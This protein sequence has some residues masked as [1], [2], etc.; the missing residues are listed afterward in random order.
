VRLALISNL[1]PGPGRGGAERYAATLAGA[2]AGCGHEVTLYTG[3]EGSIPGVDC[4]RLPG[5]PELDPGAP[6]GSK[7]RWH[8]REQWLPGVHRALR[9]ALRAS[10][11]DVVHTHETQLLSAAVFTAIA[12]AKVPHV[13]TA[14]DYNLLC[15]RV[16]M[17][18]D[19]QPCGGECGDCRIQRAIRGRAIQRRLD[20]LLAPSDFVRER[21]VAYGIV[22]PDRA[23]TI[24]HGAAPSRARRRRPAPGRLRLGFLGSL[25]EHKGVHTLLHA[26]RTMPTA[27]T[28]TIAGSGPLAGEVQA[29][30]AGDARVRFVGEVDELSRDALLDGLDVIVIPS[31][32]EEPATLVAVEAAVRGLPAIVSDR[33]GLPETP[34]AWVFDAG[35]GEAL[36]ALL[37]QL[38][39]DADAVPDRSQALLDSGSS[40]HWSTHLEAVEGALAGVARSA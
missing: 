22:A 15:T 14:H 12:S 16:T 38:A 10:R 40:Y 7:L 3:A 21:H 9:S 24:R 31:S 34:H 5:M 39:G 36:P 28:L 30:A 17:A 32:W 29:A 11:P 8:L 13:H 23:L 25:S 4:R 6:Q 37:S 20:L 27:W 33:G 18:R 19:G 2:L 26:V 35:D 1:L